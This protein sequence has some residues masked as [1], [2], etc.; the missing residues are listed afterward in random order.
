M[1]KKG[2]SAFILC[3]FLA[4]FAGFYIYFFIQLRQVRHEMRAQLKYL[5]ADQLQL[6]KLS[7]E[8]YKKAKVDEHEINVDGKM[9]DIARMYTKADTVFVYGVHDKAE[10]NLLA[11][12]DKILTLP[13]KDKNSPNQV[14]K[15]TSLAFIV[16]VVLQHTTIRCVIPVTET[17]YL[18]SGTTFIQHPDSPPPKA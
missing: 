7:N 11:F 3:L 18:E 8:D 5:P 14:L 12:L 4:H 6:I 2:L 16:P 15:F 9:Y 17:G 1:I 10:D 13:L